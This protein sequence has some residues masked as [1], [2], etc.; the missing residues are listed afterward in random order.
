MI[1]ALMI[2][3]FFILI[4]E[5]ASI[6]EWISLHIFNIEVVY[7]VCKTGLECFSMEWF[8]RNYIYACSLSGLLFLLSFQIIYLRKYIIQIFSFVFIHLGIYCFFI[9][10]NPYDYLLAIRICETILEILF[11]VLIW[12][13]FWQ[14][15]NKDNVA[16][17]IYGILMF[18]NLYLFTDVLIV[19]NIKNLMNP[20]NFTSIIFII[21]VISGL[22][23]YR[24]K[25]IVNLSN[26]KS[27]ELKPGRSYLVFKPI[28]KLESFIKPMLFGTAMHTGLIIDEQL[29]GYKKNKKYFGP[30]EE[31]DQ[32]VIIHIP[33]PDINISKHLNK[34]QFSKFRFTCQYTI[35]KILKDQ[36][37]TTYQEIVRR[38]RKH[39]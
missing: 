11:I 32:S 24:L 8:I 10:P 9:Y 30:I 26:I 18:I 16:K 12:A 15:N 27:V 37:G 36:L 31:K 20:T 17:C 2:S 5:L 33:I 35:N 6:Y 25:T 22:A 29:Y 34:Y 39:V 3:T 1:K 19:K 7:P 4:G 38:W 13:L 23:F 21:F 14:T 28:H